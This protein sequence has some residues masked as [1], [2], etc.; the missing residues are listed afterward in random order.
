MIINLSHP[1]EIYSQ[2]LFYKSLTFLLFLQLTH[3]S[4]QQ[5]WKPIDPYVIGLVH[6][7]PEW[8]IV[9]GFKD[10]CLDRLPR[11]VCCF[12]DMGQG[13]IEEFEGDIKLYWSPSPQEAWRFNYFTNY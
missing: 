12:F 8:N 7:N 13:S 4:I 2:K 6:K 1:A 9:A 3:L 5:I 11:F 10:I